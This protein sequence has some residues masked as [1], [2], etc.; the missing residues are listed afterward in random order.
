MSNDKWLLFEAS[1]FSW[2]PLQKLL[3]YQF[4]HLAFA[5]NLSKPYMWKGIIKIFALQAFWGNPTRQ[6]W[7]CT[8][9]RAWDTASSQS[10]LFI[11]LKP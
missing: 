5:F 3:I 10:M 4:Y 7:Y 2:F 8:W 6:R 1:N 9:S 11:V